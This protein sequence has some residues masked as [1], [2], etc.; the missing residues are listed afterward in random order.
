MI[1]NK[2]KLDVSQILLTFVALVG[3]VVKTAEALNLDP[4]VVQKLADA[5]GWNTKIQRITLLAGS[6]RPGDFERAQNRALSFVQG[7][8][9]R[10]LLDS[11]ITH[12]AGME[13]DEIIDAIAVRS[14]SGAKQVSARFFT[15]LAAAAEKAHHMTY[16]ALG[17]TATDRAQRDSEPDEMNASALH[18]AVLASLNAAGAAVKPADVIVRELAQSCQD[19]TPVTERTALERAADVPVP[20]L[21]AQAPSV[22]D[23]HASNQTHP[24]PHD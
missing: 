22:R 10:S 7:H 9:I 24:E 3:D 13:P 1:L 20:V 17:D 11:I 4:E 5:E 6:G 15:D 18:A 8:R 23:F 21:P 16:A 14:K 2:N 12:F 19:V